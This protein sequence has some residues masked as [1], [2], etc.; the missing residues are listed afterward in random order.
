[1][2]ELGTSGGILIGG[3][4]RDGRVIGGQFYTW[5]QWAQKHRDERMDRI[6]AKLDAIMTH[7]GISLNDNAPSPLTT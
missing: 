6:E 2:L 3:D 7:L 5:E 4:F 1:M